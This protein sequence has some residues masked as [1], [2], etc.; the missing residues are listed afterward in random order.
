MEKSA[1]DDDLGARSLGV[2]LYEPSYYDGAGYFSELTRQGSAWISFNPADPDVWADEREI[3]LDAAGYPTALAPDQ[4]AR[5]IIALESDT[6]EPGSHTLT[7]SGQGEIAVTVNGRTTRVDDR[8]DRIAENRVE[9][10]VSEGEEVSIFLEVLATDSDNTLGDIRLWA[11]GAEPDGSIFSDRLRADLEPFSTIRFMDWNKTN[12]GTHGTWEDRATWDQ[13]SWAVDDGGPFADGVPYE[14]MIDLGN[15]LGKDMWIT[16]PHQADEGYVRALA[17]LLEDR[18]DHELTVTVEFSNEAWN[19]IFP[20]WQDLAEEAESVREA[21]GVEDYYVQQH[22]GRRAIEVFEIFE[23]VFE[24]DNRV[25]TT[26]SGQ[27]GWGAILNGTMEEIEAQGGLDLV[28]QLA[29][30]PYFPDAEFGATLPTVEAALPGGITESEWAAIFEALEADVRAQFDPTTDAGA[31]MAANLAVAERYGLDLV[32]YEAGQH[33]TAWET[34]ALEGFVAEANGRAEMAAIYELY[35]D[36]WEAFSAGAEMTLY[37]LAGFWGAGEAFG[38]K[39]FGGQSASESPKYSAVLDWLGSAPVVQPEPDPEPV[40]E[41]EP[42]PQPEDLPSEVIGTSGADTLFGTDGD[43]LYEGLQGDDVFLL[44]GGDDVYEGG[45]DTDV[46]IAPM[47]RAEVSTTRDDLGRVVLEHAYG[48]A[49]LND[50]ERITLEDG[51][52]LLGSE[53][54]EESFVYLLYKAGIGRTPD[55]DGFLFWQGAY[56]AGLGRTEM[57]DLFLSS[58]EFQS[59]LGG[60]DSVASIVD[61]LY[62]E[63]LARD[64]DPAGRDFWIG[65]VETGRLDLPDLLTAF[66]VNPET[67]ATHA[68]DFEAGFWVT[69]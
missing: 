11:P 1:S 19:G 28:E 27:A 39:A 18:L 64:A 42:E 65:E 46:A 3:A 32:T 37:H 36:L 31:E 44:S 22:Y 47:V 61:L 6:V 9:V 58:N 4:A 12:Y 54:P 67:V 17:Q 40:P 35:L 20:V 60:D 57:A 53:G 25:I 49:T 66:A 26:I 5:M 63:I 13:A 14:A 69:T 51:A 21:E 24:D 7:W 59:R 15:E 48:T 50:V 2:G 23:A 8:G 16:V 38:L 62:G 45:A 41:P 29:I 55:M 34:P 30:A 43:D 68:P 56:E 33:L 52:F 10:D